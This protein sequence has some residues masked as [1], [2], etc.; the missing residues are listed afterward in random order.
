MLIL[1]LIDVQFLQNVV[2]S[3]EKIQMVK[4]THLDSYHPI[5]NPPACQENVLGQ[6]SRF[7]LRFYPFLLPL[8]ADHTNSTKIS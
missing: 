8:L 7:W 6:L 3:F 1:I 2:F 5:K 4:I